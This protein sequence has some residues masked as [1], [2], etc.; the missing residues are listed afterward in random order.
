MIR[1]TVPATTANLGPGFDTLGLALS[2]YDVFEVERAPQWQVDGCE[3]KFSG[4]DNL[5]LQS[6]RHTLHLL[7]LEPIPVH[8]KIS[9]EI[10]VARGLGSSAALCVGGAVAAL[11]LVRECSGREM[12][13]GFDPDELEFLVD[14]ASEMEGHPDNAAPGVL[15]GFCVAIMAETC[16]GAAR[17]V[18]ASRNPVASDWRFHALVPPFELETKKARAVLPQSISRADAVFNVGRAALVSQAICRAD[19]AMLACACEDR[20]HQPYR[21]ALIPG[22]DEILTACKAA[23]ADAVWLSGA[24]PTLVALTVGP[25]KTGEFTGRIES[26]LKAGGQWVHKSLSPDNLGVSYVCNPD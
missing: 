19:A 15:G 1:I 23:G 3:P 9:A 18:I 21:K 24:G 20:I 22:Y 26:I 25:A 2:L 8:L 10:P 12:K 4:E 7:G 14:A 13:P 17:H 16:Q 11:L 5:F 6:F